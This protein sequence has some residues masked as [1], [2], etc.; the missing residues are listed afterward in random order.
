MN[1]RTVVQQKATM[2]ASTSMSSALLPRKCACGGTLGVDGECAECRDKRLSV[3]RST[4][5]PATQPPT[6]PPII[7]EVLHSS[8]QPLDAAT[9]AF[10]EPRFGHDFSQV[11]VHTDA[12]AAESARTVNALAYTVGRDVVFGKGQY[13]PTTIA[14]QRLL[15]HELTHVVQQGGSA[16][17][18]P[19][20]EHHYIQRQVA[21]TSGTSRTPWDDLP[22]NA[23]QAIDNTYFNEKLDRESQSAFRS[24][25]S[26]LV[27]EGL[28]DDVGRVDKVFPKNV[29]GI[30]ASSKG[31]LAGKLL[32]NPHFCRD[33][34]IGG[35]QHGG[36][37]MWRQVVQAGTEGLH[38]GISGRNRMVAHLDVLAPVGGREPDG[39]CRYSAPHILPHVLRDLAGWRNLEFLP[40]PTGKE[41]P[42][43][44]Q[45]LIRISIPGT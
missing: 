43:D 36:A 28:W 19:T 20:E 16:Y 7:N 17:F 40:A 1:K 37:V 24:V 13:V 18:N 4:T 42:G 8:G 30:E 35:S 45:P 39:R 32:S 29:R 14:G 41:Q 23:R 2:P 11:R 9:R 15:A 31:G 27:T 5:N 25:Y 10:M 44:V 34:G 38:V 33:T 6:V 21:S 3:Q 26:A 12:R 22:A